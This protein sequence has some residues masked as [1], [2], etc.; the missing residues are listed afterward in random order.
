[1]D[2]W[3]GVGKMSPLRRGRVRDSYGLG[4]WGKLRRQRSSEVWFQRK[5]EDRI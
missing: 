5:S 3:S 1:V 4:M 2:W